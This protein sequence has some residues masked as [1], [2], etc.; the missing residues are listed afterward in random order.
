MD[1]ALRRTLIALGLIL[2]AAG[3]ARSLGGDVVVVATGERVR[4]RLSE[5]GFDRAVTVSSSISD[6]S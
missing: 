6:A 5:N 2:G 4:Q 1:L 3:R